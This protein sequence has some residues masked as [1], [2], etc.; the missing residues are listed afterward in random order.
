MHSDFSSLKHFWPHSISAKLS[1]I[2]GSLLF[3]FGLSPKKW[4]IQS[5]RSPSVFLFGACFLIFPPALISISQTWQSWVSPGKGYIP[6]YFS[7]FGLAALVAPLLL[8]LVR[9]CSKVQK[10]FNIR[11]SIQ[12]QEIVKIGLTVCLGWI[13]MK[14][15]LS[16]QNIAEIMDE[17]YKYPRD[18]LTES[19]DAGI[20]KGSLPGAVFLTPVRAQWN[21]KN[22]SEKVFHIFSVMEFSEAVKDPS[23]FYRKE[24]IYFLDLGE[25]KDQNQHKGWVFFSKVEEIKKSKKDTKD[26]LKSEF[27][28]ETSQ[29]YFQ[30]LKGFH[31]SVRVSCKNKTISIV[32][33]TQPI[34]IGNE[35]QLAKLPRF[36]CLLNQVKVELVFK[37]N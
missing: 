23:I 11:E 24:G 1:V 15:H 8:E 21:T 3:Y 33:Q 17:T 31:S 12:I 19:Y 20:V 16:N 9:N 13:L 28:F 14:N 5:I 36:R 4:P 2:F 10:K 30:N 34:L 22:L 35:P 37:A 7:Y 29:I 18:L 26:F 27:V 6:V 32:N 25:N